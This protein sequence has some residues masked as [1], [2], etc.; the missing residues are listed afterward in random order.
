MFER[1]TFLEDVLNN[2]Q[3]NH[4][5]SVRSPWVTK[6]RALSS[7]WCETQARGHLRAEP[8]GEA[9]GGS[10]ADNPQAGEER[11]TVPQDARREAQG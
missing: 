10:A 7:G 4:Y 5:V 11:L 1:A 9:T 8:R 2:K 6:R 3:L